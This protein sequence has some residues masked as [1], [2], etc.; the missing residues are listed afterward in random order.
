MAFMP[1]KDPSTARR[2]C[3]LSK[4]WYLG[5]AAS[6]QIKQFALLQARIRGKKRLRKKRKMLDTLP[7]R[8]FLK[9]CA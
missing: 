3:D 6:K 4:A 2:F 7:Q 9:P 1:G 5:R 8:L